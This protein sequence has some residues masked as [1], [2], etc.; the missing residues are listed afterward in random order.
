MYVFFPIR[1]NVLGC[2]R[3]VNV[4]QGNARVGLSE[5]NVQWGNVL[6]PKR[7]TTLA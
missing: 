1:I 7:H 6:K 2:C 5:G 4:L 3:D